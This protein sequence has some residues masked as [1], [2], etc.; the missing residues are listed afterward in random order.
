[1]HEIQ[2]QLRPHAKK[3]AAAPGTERGKLPRVAEVL[4]LAIGFDDMIRRG[5][6][7][8]HSDLARLGCISKERVSQIMRLVWL[9]PDIQQEIL[10][11]PRTS[12]GRFNV[13][14]VVL[15]QVA[16]KMLWGAQRETWAR[17][18]TG[19]E[20]ILGGVPGRDR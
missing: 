6:A 17:I 7:K 9:A 15:R 3:E 8:D 10:T 18:A 11:L 13:G 4:A 14:E 19:R 5:L 2:F 1:M 12:L 20:E 16:S